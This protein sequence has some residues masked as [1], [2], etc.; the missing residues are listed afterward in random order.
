[1]AGKWDSN[2]KRLVQANP[3]DFIDWLHEGAH[4]KRE[5]TVEINR[6]IHVDLLYETVIDGE[7][8]IT[9]IEFQRYE[10]GDMTWRVLEYTVFI[11]C[12]YKRPVRSFVIYLKKE[13]KIAEPPLVIPG[14]NR[15]DILRFNFTNVKLW[16][17]PTEKL[18]LMNSVGILPLLPL[19]REG[20]TPTVVD[21]ALSRIRQAD[22]DRKTKEELLTITFA[23]A[24][25]GLKKKE[26]KDWL[27][28]R[29]YMLRDI[30]KDTEIYQI[31]MEEGWEKGLEKG[32]EEG[33]EAFHQLILE[34][35]QERFPELIEMAMR[36][37]NVIADLDAL[38]KLA[39]KVVS[40]N[41]ANQV[42]ALLEESKQN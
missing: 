42:Q 19:T 4:I 9:H 2:L 23:L 37:V 20:G 18:S 35:I 27:I 22:I 29:F 40:A 5:L 16:G 13:G 25:L 32:R 36:R 15:P 26:D 10:D 30:I 28:R 6:L 1:M 24:T 31:I 33:L 14:G 21:E 34:D 12:K 17:I 38:K 8:E 3:Q 41:S 39:R 7:I 11:A